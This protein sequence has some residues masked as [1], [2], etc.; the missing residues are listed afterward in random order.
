MGFLPAPQSLGTRCFFQHHKRN[1]PVSQLLWAG[2]LNKEEINAIHFH[3]SSKIHYLQKCRA[4][5]VFLLQII[6]K[7]RGFLLRKARGLEI[8]TLKYI[9]FKL[10]SKIEKVNRAQKYVFTNCISPCDGYCLALASSRC[11]VWEINDMCSN[12][13]ERSQAQWVVLISHL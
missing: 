4:D 5:P 2:V 9:C 3:S 10:V 1:P 12:G 6:F 13:I 11:Q 8:Q 7:P